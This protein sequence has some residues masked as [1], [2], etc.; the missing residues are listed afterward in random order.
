MVVSVNMLVSVRSLKTV[1]WKLSPWYRKRER[2]EFSPIRL[3]RVSGGTYFV[4][5]EHGSGECSPSQHRRT[6]EAIRRDVGIGDVQVGDGT[7][8]RVDGRDAECNE[9]SKRL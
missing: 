6:F 1:I 8:G 7:N 4:A 2:S 9:S 5:R 3:Q